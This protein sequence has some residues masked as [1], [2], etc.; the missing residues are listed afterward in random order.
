[1]LENPEAYSEQEIRDII[2]HD[3]ETREAYRLMVAAKQGYTHKQTNHTTNAQAAWQRFC[4]SEKFKVKSEKPNTAHSTAQLH[5]SFFTLH[6]SFQKIVASF[7]GILLVSSITFAAIH[8]VRQ[9]QKQESP[10]T[11]QTATVAKT[12]NTIPVDT[13]TTDTTTI[14]PVIFDNIPLEKM[15]SEIATHYSAE[16]IF[17]NNEI[18]SF[19]FHFVW[20]PQQEIEKVVSNLNHFERLHVIMKENQLIVE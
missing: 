13:L 5:S 18:R 7:I 3:D 16:V 11:E 20:N 9:H 15:L 14:Q 4:E 8:I 12:T 1:M 10:Q 6:S 2:N 17:Q 19:R